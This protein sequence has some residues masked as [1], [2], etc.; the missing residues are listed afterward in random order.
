MSL[1]LG[2]D[3]D[4]PGIVEVAAARL[5]GG[6]QLADLSPSRTRGSMRPWT[7]VGSDA[8]IILH[9]S[10]LHFGLANQGEVF[11]TLLAFL[12]N[13]L[14]SEVVAVL[15]TGDIV[16]SPDE[17]IAD[18]ARR[19]L[20]SLCDAVR[21]SHE[22]ELLTVAGNHDV[23]RLGNYVPWLWPRPKRTK[24]FETTFQRYLATSKPRLVTAGDWRIGVIGANTAEF[25]DYFARGYLPATALEDIKAAANIPDVDLCLLLLHHHLLPVRHLE[26]RRR[27]SVK[28]LAAVTN[29]VNGASSTHGVASSGVDIVLH[30]HEH[31][32]NLLGYDS[33]DT[34]HHQ[35]IV[36]GAGSAGGV[37]GR[38]C[39]VSAIGFN[40]L[41]LR[42][43]GEV[44][45][46]QMA[47]DGSGFVFEERHLLTAER[48][49]RS[50]TLRNEG[51][52]RGT[53]AQKAAPGSFESSFTKGVVFRRNRDIDIR[54]EM[55][56]W[57][58]TDPQIV[59]PVQN[60]TGIPANAHV[61]VK[62]DT[63]LLAVSDLAIVPDPKNAQRWAIA[64][65]TPPDARNAT[66]D[67]VLSYQW[68]AGALLT[69]RELADAGDRAR[70]LVR[71]EGREY[72]TLRVPDVVGRAQIALIVPR[73]LAPAEIEVKVFDAE[74]KIVSGASREA[75]TRLTTF[76]PGHYVLDVKYPRVGWRYTL[77]WEP[78]PWEGA[79]P[80]DLAPFADT[81]AFLSYVRARLPDSPDRAAWKM[82]LYLRT[83]EGLRLVAED[84]RPGLQKNEPVVGDRSF[85]AQACW[86]VPIMVERGAAGMMPDE[87][88]A[89]SLPLVTSLD[90][91]E[92]PLGVL[93][94][95]YPTEISGLSRSF[96]LQL[97]EATI[98]A[99][100]RR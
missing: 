73:T 5:V 85:V 4:L 16:D 24:T 42:N 7:P 59:F 28:A 75:R 87:A 2:G 88:V 3:V 11:Q 54:I 20:V 38:R 69:K 27:A 66:V 84:G 36:I 55:K 74:E 86:G 26:D 1:A 23:H 13:N 32:A 18:Q 97:A 8:R 92:E 34:G 52:R 14:Q 90:G 44:L 40:I 91:A 89:W 64:W 29:L 83:V 72:A 76:A 79:S 35:A 100:I 46:R 99:L 63:G 95:S 41:V 61:V 33:L 45:L 82:A 77:A 80:A 50:R 53:S 78:A 58:L 12:R 94:I 17:T 56:R 51:S 71:G 67:I 21:Q 39:Q 68:L 62:G 96:H 60:S 48:L 93:R 49:R 37:K 81:R 31:A 65:R 57:R 15:V 25:A 22:V 47:H 10:D 9:L 70:E 19:D 43:D 6:G 30:G 98:A